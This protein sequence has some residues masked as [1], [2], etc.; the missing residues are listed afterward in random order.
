MTPSP[1]PS[2]RSRWLPHAGATVLGL[3]GLVFAP[4]PML[5]SRLELVQG[6]SVDARLN[7]HI[8]EHGYRALRPGP[9]PETLWTPLSFFPV[10][11]TA[12]Y[13]E[14]LLGAAPPY[15]VLR[16]LGAE[17]DTA[18]QLW[19][20]VVS[21]LDFA[22]A[23]LLLHRSLGRGPAA[24]AAGAFLFAFASP[25]L[26]QVGIGHPQFLCQF[27]SVAAVMALVRAVREEDRE[28][29][30]RVP[31]AIPAFCACAT[32]QIY[33]CVYLGWL[34]LFTLGVAS[35]WALAFEG[36]RR[37]LLAVVR[38]RWGVLLASAALSA[39]ANP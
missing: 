5:L 22:L 39:V 33:A 29:A 13:S 3:V 24:S 9:S 18:F 34:F 16:A 7:N 17:P 37:P 20:L 35:L 25:R 26:A 28:E 11:N 15:W 6:Y 23:Y 12:V 2:P 38:R 32:G 30:R 1:A 19:M 10:P 27:W 21:A 8:L 36:S 31:L 14:T 4:H